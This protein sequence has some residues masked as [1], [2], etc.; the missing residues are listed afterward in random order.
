MA[1]GSRR[2]PT[3]A[4]VPRVFRSDVL[5]RFAHCDPAGIVFYPRY[6]EMFNALVEDWFLDELGISFWEIHARRGWGIPT[7]HL[8]V[9]F[10]AYSVLGELLSA[11]LVVRKL[12]TSSIDVQIVLTGP[13]GNDRVRGRVVLVL[14]DAATRRACPIPPDLRTRLTAFLAPA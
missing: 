1:D 10:V 2:V 14:I 12:G 6:F 9:D 3:A 5:V 8:E 13:D 7:V 4:A 11:S